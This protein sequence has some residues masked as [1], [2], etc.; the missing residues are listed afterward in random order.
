MTCGLVVL[1]GGEGTRVRELLGNKPK[2]SIAVSGGSSLLALIIDEAATR[3]LPIC[4]VVD[5]RWRQAVMQSLGNRAHYPTWAVDAGRGT[6]VALLA[7]LRELSTTYAIVCNADTVVPAEIFQL[8]TLSSQ[9]LPV[10]QLLTRRSMQNEGLIGVRRHPAGAVV[11]HWGETDLSFP[12]EGLERWSSSG[13]YLVDRS[14]FISRFNADYLSLERDVLPELVR[15]GAV[16]ALLAESPLPTYDF[17][18]PERLRRL[19]EEGSLRRSLLHAM[20]ILGSDG[21]ETVKVDKRDDA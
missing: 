19:S 5:E 21:A 8:A 13:V 20:G 11:D 14:Y 18:T 4:V 15:A 2:A 1:A 12:G 17:G 16:G 10:T 6:G 9:D 3:Q 7:G